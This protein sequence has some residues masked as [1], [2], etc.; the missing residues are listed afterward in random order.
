MCVVVANVSKRLPSCFA[1]K[2]ND[3]F[4]LRPKVDCSIKLSPDKTPFSCPSPLHLDS[5]PPL[6][7]HR[8]RLSTM[9]GEKTRRRG[10]KGSERRNFTDWSESV[11][12]LSWQK[13]ASGKRVPHS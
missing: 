5:L 4:P 7:F 3:L 2:E 1:K 10:D 9:R 6:P 12:R 8:R 11:V 13:P